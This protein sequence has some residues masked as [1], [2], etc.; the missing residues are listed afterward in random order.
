[1]KY[2]AYAGNYELGKE[3]LGTADK[4]LIWDLTAMWA[5][6]R[7]CRRVFGMSFR[8]YSYT[9]FYDDKTFREI[10]H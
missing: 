2:Y 5:I 9:N 7:R 8:L 3:P 1:M 10:R 6:L 4:L